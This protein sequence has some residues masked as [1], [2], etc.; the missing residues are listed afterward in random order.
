MFLFAL[1]GVDGSG[2]STFASV[3]ASELAVLSPDL[4]VTRLWLRYSPRRSAPGVVSSTVSAKH[5][6]H[7][8]KHGLRRA[9]L[10]SA[11]IWLN[12]SVY[13][14]Q[15]EWQ[16]GAAHNL[17][18][19]VADRFV[20]DFLVDQVSAGLLDSSRAAA[21]AKSLPAPDSAVHL[22]VDDAELL[23]RLKPGDDPMRLLRHAAL[24]RELAGVLGVPQLD[25][26]DSDSPARAATMI[27]AGLR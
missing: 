11:W 6:G 5:H 3:L 26:R 9:G 19:V 13:R 7:P 14:R 23:R 25:G 1:S 2:K 21:V 22:D 18:V 12:T 27:L 15:L 4:A 24:Y 16:L 10:S 20:L 17:D 8:L